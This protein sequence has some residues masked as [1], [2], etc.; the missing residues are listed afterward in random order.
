MGS[1]HR[2][3]LIT[4]RIYHSIAANLG[5][6]MDDID[7]GVV[8]LGDGAHVPDEVHVVKLEERE[9]AFQ[10]FRLD[11]G[12]NAGGHVHPVSQPVVLAVVHVNGRCY[13]REVVDWWYRLKGT[14]LLPFISFI[15]C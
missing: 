5:V 10:V 2:T 1:K 4:I 12:D 13:Y 6:F 8:D 11:V 3:K 14:L 15:S 9:V 7:D